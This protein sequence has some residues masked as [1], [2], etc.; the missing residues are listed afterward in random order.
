MKLVGE[1]RALAAAIMAFYFLLY[2]LLA[3]AGDPAML[4]ALLA[5][6]GVYGLAFFS[7]VAGYFWARWFS[8]GVGLYGVVIATVGLWQSSEIPEVRPV[9]YFIGGTHLA[10]TLLLWGQTMSEPY[11]GQ[12]AWRERFHMDDSAVQRLGRSVIRAGIGLP[13][14]L[15]YA[16]AP[17]EPAQA[18]LP[19]VAFG[20]AAFGLRGLIQ[21]RTWGVLA[22]GLAGG[23]T[24]ALVGADVVAHGLSALAP[25]VVAGTRH[26]I[27]SHAL[28]PLAGGLLVASAAPFLAPIARYLAR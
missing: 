26:V 1:R 6:A 11:D 28:A 4:K 14:V 10:A 8:V 19:L 17:R 16:F 12:S 23:L 24:L 15:I 20:L 9:L 7:L 27:I 18:I 13:I 21:L 5:I 25:H 3:Y 22:L 2:A